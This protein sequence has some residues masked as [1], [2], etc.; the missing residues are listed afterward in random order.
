M[1][2]SM[3]GKDGSF[4]HIWSVA[5][6]LIIMS[7][8]L[9]VMQIC[10]RKFLSMQSTDYVAAALPAGM[11]AFN[12]GSLFLI[13]TNF[14]ASV[15]SQYFGKRDSLSCVSAAWSAISFALVSGLFI[16]FVL[17]FLGVEII[18]YAAANELLRGLQIEYF[19]TLSPSVAFACLTGACCSY[20]S[21]QGLTK[22]VAIAN[23]F[24]MLVNVGLD[25]ILIFGH[26]GFPEFGIG[27]IPE[28][29][30]IGAGVA[31][32][33]AA[34]TTALVSL[35]FFFFYRP[36][37]ML[38]VI[39]H[40]KFDLKMIGKI[41]KFGFPVGL[42]V[43]MDVSAWFIAMSMVGRISDAAA[44]AI[45]ITVS[46]NQLSFMPMLGF[47]DAAS[48][49]FGQNVGRKKFKLGEIIIYR[50]WLMIWVYMA[51]TAI[52]YLLFP[53]ELINFFAPSQADTDFATVLEIGKISLTCAAFYNFLD[54][55]KFILMGALRGAGDTKILVV[56][57]V[58]ACWL[59]MVPAI[60]LT[61]LVF[62]GTI[63]NVWMVFATLIF[64]QNVAFFLRF[65]SRKWAKI[66]LTS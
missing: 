34:L 31:T 14:T 55:L 51:I 60:S 21:G 58:L 54:S 29:G 52:F 47:A 44:A 8:T 64:I 2:S 61:I 53:V 6:P 10:D 57:V 62:K 45:T 43:V 35:A 11:L 16:S 13:T 41:F 46:I 59:F 27:A 12:M 22:V 23:F 36:N 48:I 40:I 7:A 49:I 66:E 50:S 26:P 9:T 4:K 17:P 63:L 28:F 25:Y 30:I 32:S 1:L 15:V 39:E 19:I 24:G 56:V 18:K 37:N 38:K 42:M 65:K 33:I 5:Y 20:F 3:S